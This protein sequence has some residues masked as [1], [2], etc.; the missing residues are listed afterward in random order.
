MDLIIDVGDVHPANQ[1]FDKGLQIES[2]NLIEIVAVEG[3][4]L[5]PS[6]TV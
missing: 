6:S 5:L 3:G 4:P 1:G 2:D